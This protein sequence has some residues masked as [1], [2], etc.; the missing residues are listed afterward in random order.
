MIHQPAN[1]GGEESWAVN[2]PKDLKVESIL[3]I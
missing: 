3:K 2:P 1:F